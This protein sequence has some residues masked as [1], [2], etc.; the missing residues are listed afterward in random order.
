MSAPASSNIDSL[1]ASLQED[2]ASKRSEYRKRVDSIKSK[3]KDISITA[4]INAENKKESKQ[5]TKKLATSS[6]TKKASS[7]MESQETSLNGMEQVSLL[8][9]KTSVQDSKNKAGVNSQNKGST[10]FHILVIVNS[11]LKCEH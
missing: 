4:L 3:S 1:W 7:K 2:E 8:L 9:S 11:H 5:S 6:S 10:T